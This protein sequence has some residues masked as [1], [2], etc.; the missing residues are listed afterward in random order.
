MKGRKNS[1]GSSD[2]W[3]YWHVIGMENPPSSPLCS[4]RIYWCLCTQKMSLLLP[5]YKKTLMSIATSLWCGRFI[6]RKWSVVVFLQFMQIKLYFTRW[7]LGTIRETLWRGA[8]WSLSMIYSDYLYTLVSF[9][10]FKARRYPCSELQSGPRQAFS[11]SR[12]QLHIFSPD[13]ECSGCIGDKQEWG[14]KRVTGSAL[15]SVS[16]EIVRHYCQ[17]T[18]KVISS[19]INYVPGLSCFGLQQRLSFHCAGRS[20]HVADRIRRIELLYLPSHFPDNEQ[21]R[22]SCANYPLCLTFVTW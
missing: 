20:K 8:I 9:I 13:Q 19:P 11:V 14:L 18:Q 16:W 7:T 2:I 12:G 5:K 10:Y 3:E 6:E 1:C 4:K 21:W 17:L 15:I 22:E